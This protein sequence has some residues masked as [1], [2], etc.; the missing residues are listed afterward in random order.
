MGNNRK[1]RWCEICKK[2]LEQGS[3]HFFSHK[4]SEHLITCRCRKCVK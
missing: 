4:Q 2:A 1:D 3:K